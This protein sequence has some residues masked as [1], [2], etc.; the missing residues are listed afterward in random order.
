MKSLE[1]LGLLKSEPEERSTGR[2]KIKYFITELGEKRRFEIRQD[3]EKYFKFLKEN[4]IIETDFDIPSFLEKTFNLWTE[5][6]E[7]IIDSDI[8]IS[9]K[10]K[11]LSEVEDDLLDLLAKVRKEKSKLNKK[12]TIEEVSS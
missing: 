6:V 8:S 1:Q 11:A 10:I 3:V 2:P 12:N 7:R 9:G 5:P 4:S